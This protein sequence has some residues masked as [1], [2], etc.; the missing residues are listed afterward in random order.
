[1]SSLGIKSV[2]LDTSFCIR[3]LDST[4]SLH[5]NALDY[6]FHFRDNGITVHLSTIAVAEYS[7][8]DDPL[9]LPINYLQ[10]E[11]FDFRDGAT[12][13][14]LHNHLYSN[15]AN[16]PG[17]SRRI[18]ANDIKILSQIKNRT[19]DGIITKDTSSLNKYVTPLKTAGLINV[20][21]LDLNTPLSTALGQLF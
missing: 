10:I 13:G 3:L 7:V 6:F 4:E 17:Y 5:Q 12:A 20:K 11:T 1:M 16:I 19:I 18:V 21:F 8:L 2:M 14:K 9:N 15:K